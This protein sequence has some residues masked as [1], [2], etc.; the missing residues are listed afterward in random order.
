[1]LLY[2]LGEKIKPLTII[3]LVRVLPDY[4]FTKIDVAFF[5]LCLVPYATNLADGRGG[6]LEQV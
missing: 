3:V 5:F 4:T 6:F 1:M 2:L